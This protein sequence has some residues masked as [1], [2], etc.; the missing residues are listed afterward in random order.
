[1]AVLAAA[2]C[3]WFP[4]APGMARAATFHILLGSDISQTVSGR[5]L[6]FA[7]PVVAAKV[8]GDAA[9]P[10]DA[11]PFQPRATSVAGRE[12]HDLQPGEVLDMDADEEAYPQPFSALPP[13]RYAVQAVFDPFHTYAF[14]G[15]G[16]QDFA[17][18]PTV[19]EL[20]AGGTF[21]LDRIR[22]APPETSAVPPSGQTKPDD[23][24]AH[25][26]PFD[27]AS[28]ALTR[29]WGRP[30]D[31]RAWV[32]TPPGYGARPG[33]HYLTVYLFP[34]FSVTTE[35]LLGR[36][37]QVYAAMSSGAAPPMLWVFLDQSGPG[38]T[39]E[40]ADSVNNGPWG[41][42]LTTEFIPVFEQRFHTDGRPCGRFLTG[43]SS[44]GW[45]SLWLQVNYPGVFGGAWSTSPDPVS[46]T[47]FSGVDLYAPGANLYRRPDDSAFP[48][49]RVNGKVQVSIEDY[50]R[51]EAVLS[52]YGGQMSSFDWVF[53]PR[54]KDGRPQPMFD[55]TTGQVD[56][57]VIAYWKDHYDISRLLT[58]AWPAHKS[59]LDGKLH[60]LVGEADNFY[61]DGAVRQLQ[62]VLDRLGAR[63]DIHYLP[64]R[65]HF[66][67]YQVGADPYGR[68]N[69]FAWEMYAKARPAPSF[70]LD[71]K[72]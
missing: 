70:P 38:G 16:P 22:P 25:L 11:V 26:H 60:V 32:L 68:L 57:D 39:H 62:A 34:G 48:F 4:A 63:Y 8:G 5:L 21:V 37:K 67:M 55:R 12:V 51:L 36:A 72:R 44:G 31:V 45:A 17:S 53:S 61:L 23:V 52:P 14:V 59:E 69:A 66:D 46:F 50:A 20:P 19:L 49:M 9:R 1:M 40:F 2:A 27:V 71:P 42:A 18:A 13:G 41:Q 54:G 28:G 35:K 15:R 65:T 47:D 43:H 6:V 64:G 33:D 10:V 30:V 7:K 56:P 58:R 3:L 24:Q 29:F